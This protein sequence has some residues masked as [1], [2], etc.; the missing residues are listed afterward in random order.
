ML[1]SLSIRNIVLI[2][3]ADV[4]FS[5]GLCVLT[6]ETGSGKSIFLDALMLALGVRSSSRLLRDGKKN[7]S[8]TAVFDVG[9]NVKCQ[10]MLRELAID[11]GNEIILRRILS[12]DGRSKAFVNDVAVG[13]NFLNLLG[14]NLVEVH[15][16][17][18]Q[19]G[20]L[21]PSFH[22][23]ML[24]SY[25]G[26]EA[27]RYIVSNL[28]S[29]MKNIEAQLRE[30]NQQKEDIAREIDYLEYALEE[31]KNMD[32]KTGEEEE[33][34]SRR[35]L[36]LS[37]DKIMN[38]LESV[39]GM[40]C[41][42]S[43]VAKAISN[44]QNCLSRNRLLG[45]NLLEDGQNIFDLVI[46]DFEKSLLEFNEGIRK[47]DLACDGGNFEEVSLEE[48]EERLFAIRSLARKYSVSCDDF[49]AFR[50]EM[51]KKLDEARN[52]NVKADSLSEQFEIF[53][54]KYL[55]EAVR[56]REQRKF[57][58]KQLENVLLTELNAVSSEN[59]YFVVEFTE[60]SV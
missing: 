32:V 5:G 6:G 33:L 50:D 26:L 25:G 41:G 55:D 45:E 27:Q 22:R 38:T 48:V 46:E 31:L 21:N 57:T 28:Y 24:D 18:E 9:D 19:R 59:T 1:R 12:E 36:L 47:I 34:N 8:V 3:E 51:E 14:E 53:S 56:L 17:H 23:D 39:K 52:K 2:E 40:V 13:Q 37:R 30:L 35:T 7:G 11:F 4:D 10:E 49:S 54:K 44:A 20:L 16:Q 60:L 42:G 29:E 58:A 43:G 15:G